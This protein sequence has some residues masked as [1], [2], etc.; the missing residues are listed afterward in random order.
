MYIFF[1]YWYGIYF[2]LCIWHLDDFKTSISILWYWMIFCEC[3][4]FYVRQIVICMTFFCLFFNISMYLYVYM[5]IFH[6][7]VDVNINVHE[8]SKIKMRLWEAA[9][10]SLRSQCDRQITSCNTV[11]ETWWIHRTIHLILVLTACVQVNRCWQGLLKW[12]DAQP[13]VGNRQPVKRFSFRGFVG[14]A[15]SAESADTT[16]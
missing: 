3:F 2:L 14:T 5:Q 4:P 15:Q 10:C 12:I 6:T 11:V 7:S 16:A 1:F 13:H 9:R 8:L